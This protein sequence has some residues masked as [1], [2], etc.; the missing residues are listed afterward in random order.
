MDR[1]QASVEE[2]G[3][4]LFTYLAET[5]P[6]TCGSDE[7]YYFPH[8]R[9]TEPRWSVWDQFSTESVGHIL[10]HLSR[11]ESDLN[12]LIMDGSDGDTKVDIS[13][14][15]RFVHT[16]KEQLDGYKFWRVQP[17]FYLTLTCSGL[18]EAMASDNPSAIH[19]RAST[20][21]A[22]LDQ[23]VKNLADVPVIFRELGL[24]M[25]SDVRQFV[26]SLEKTAPD[27][28]HTQSALDRF[29][30]ALMTVRTRKDFMMPQDRL[31]HLIKSHLNTGMEIK[32]VNELLDQEIEEMKQVMHRK[33]GKLLDDTVY[34]NVDWESWRTVYERLPLP[35]VNT[36]DLLGLFRE[37]VD[38][39]MQ[40]CLDQ[41]LI[42]TEQAVSCPVRVAPMPSYLSAIR[43][44][45]SY[46]ILP[47][48]PPSGGT[49]YIFQNR[50]VGRSTAESL[51]EYRMLA[52]HET[53]P[54]HHL[55]DTWRLGLKRFSR[56]PVE[57]PVFYEGWACFAEEIMRLTGYFSGPADEFL[58]AKRRFWRAVRGKADLG[59][60]MGEMSLAAAA[61]YLQMAGMSEGRAASSVR[62]YP[63]NP[64]YQLCYTIG[65]RRFLGLFERCGG[66]QVSLFV[67]RILGQGEILFSDLESLLKN[68]LNQS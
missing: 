46:S 36:H 53:Y 32:E 23:A 16:L 49:F 54:G 40:H 12:T 67:R 52:S 10:E 58:L 31:K 63:L 4:T 19:D 9:L 29:G 42:L 43:T 15:T 59:L 21:P 60:Q 51:R 28:I 26:S 61:N 5:F 17:T 2:L 55:L 25:V 22:F 68:A 38:R 18:A 66:D 14:L 45:S 13:L 64:G 47:T 6:V 41:S 62:K 44:A 1:P 27:L 30:K 11:W 7:F 56:V 35:Q 57:Q 65:L 48:I 24:E 39:L 50:R 37:E 3:R 8:F 33:A 34:A 20:L